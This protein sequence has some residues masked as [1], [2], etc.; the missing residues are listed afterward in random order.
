MRAVNLAY[1][2]G[3]PTFDILLDGEFFAHIVLSVPGK[4]NVYNALAAAASAHLCGLSAQ[5][6]AQ[7]LRHFCGA[8][9]RMEYKGR[10]NGAAVF[11]DYGHHPTEVSATLQGMSKMGYERIFCV[12][13]PHTYSRTAQLADQFA[14]AF[15]DADRVILVDI[16]AAREKESKGISSAKLAS[17]IGTK[18]TYQPDFEKVG[19]QLCTEVTARDAVVVMGA[20]DV[21]RL[22]EKLPLEK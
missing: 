11:D 16:Y 15:A 19:E 21:Y 13:Q 2:S 3:Y 14:G 9:R 12:F 1:E 18:A 10:L 7:G 22:F 20:G 17:R 6:I 4:H 8:G 5:D